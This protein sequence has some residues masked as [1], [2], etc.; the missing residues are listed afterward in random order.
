MKRV[1][2]EKGRGSIAFSIDEEKIIDTILG[3]DIAPIEHQ[4]IASTIVRGIRASSPPDI[5]EKKI[6]IIIPD[7]T[8]LWARGDLFVPVIVQTLI[9]IGAVPSN[10]KV[11]IALGT[12]K[13]IPQ[14]Q[15]AQLAGK[16]CYKQKNLEILNSA[17][18]DR[19]RLVYLGQ[20][21]R[22]TDLL[23]TR[24]ACEADHVIIF[25]GILHHMVAGFG[26][27][28]KYIL[29]G[30]AGY[31]SIQQ[32]HSLAIERDGTPHPMVR[33]AQLEGN[34]V[35]ED[36]NE[37]AQLFLR[38]KSSC[39]VAVAAN[40]SGQL[41]HVDVGPLESTFMAGCQK[42][43][44]ACCVKVPRKGNFALISAGG[45]LSDGQ[46]YQATKAL[47]NGVNV[48]H[49]GGEIL[50][51]AEAFQGIGN[52]TFGNALKKFKGDPEKL[53][54][55][56]VNAFEMPSY[57]AF[58]VIDMLQRYRVT[59]L[60]MFNRR[61]TLEMGFNH[62]SDIDGYIRELKGQGYIIPFAENILPHS[63]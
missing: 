38:E 14:S 40:G 10:I 45:E 58:R 39:Y 55:L 36:L 44:D 12:H 42:V 16:F 21:S 61:E 35:H 7:N 29:P 37:A 5:E 62:T 60:S 63:R 8:R 34:P 18:Q 23:I 1:T 52:D 26:G 20:T 6:V 30:I 57:V 24:E 56:L 53:G 25:G 41:F 17:N 43:N 31:D 19:R 46:L 28:R 47:F 3:K 54:K 48:V 50:F 2:L 22:G 13:E 9:D 59:L 33:Q 27:G 4:D 51:V 15:F 32:N 11:I 49:E